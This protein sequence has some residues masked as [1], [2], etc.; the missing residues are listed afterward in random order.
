MIMTTVSCTK[1]IEYKGPDS[2]PMLVIN[3]IAQDGEV[4]VIQVSHS[5]FFLDYYRSGKTLD[6][7]TSVRVDINGESQ[8]AVWDDDKQAFTDDRAVHAGDIIHISASHPD[9]ANASATDTVPTPGDCMLT[10]FRKK[11][12]QH[13]TIGEL[14]NFDDDTSFDDSRIDSTWVIEIEI[15]DRNEF[16]DYYYL[17][18]TPTITYVTDW[19]EGGPI[20]T[21]TMPLHYQIPSK[22]RILMGQ[23][24]ATSSFIGRSW[25]DNEFSYGPTKH[26]FSD[27]H[28]KDGSRLT[29][30]ILM[31]RP[32]TLRGLI[33]SDVNDSLYFNNYFDPYYHNL[34]T[35]G[36]IYGDLTYTL[37][38][39]LYTLSSAY[40]FYEKSV[41]D[42]NDADLTLMSEPVT[43]ISNIKGGA[44]I[45]GTYSSR[46][47]SKTITTKF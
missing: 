10:G 31:E 27:T 42:F 38:V 12:S 15:Y 8:N 44:G 47:F 2:K 43:V 36:H 23:N 22:T 46:L 3:C 9:Y 41:S 13:K 14:F 20:D 19:Y 16:P 32:D 17:T 40:Y 39:T 18:F 34:S 4:P 7:R 33:Y 28:I 37:N 1:D 24:N 30:E 11:Y 35:T 29:F 26:I 5:V 45:L 21:V 6:N 25:E